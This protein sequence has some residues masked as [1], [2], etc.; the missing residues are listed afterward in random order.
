MLQTFVL[1]LSSCVHAPRLLHCVRNDAVPDV[2]QACDARRNAPSG[3]VIPAQEESIPFQ[4]S[5]RH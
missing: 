3:F 5:K 1:Y 4:I 2:A